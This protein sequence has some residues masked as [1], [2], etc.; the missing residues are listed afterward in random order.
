MVFQFV[1]NKTSYHSSISIALFASKRGVNKGMQIRR[2][3]LF[4][5]PIRRYFRENFPW[6]KYTANGYIYLLSFSSTVFRFYPKFSVFPIQYEI[7][8]L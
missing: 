7:V 2:S 8:A 1:T 4:S 6:V 3:V 5:K